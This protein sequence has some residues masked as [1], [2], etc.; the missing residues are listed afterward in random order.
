MSLYVDRFCG[1]LTTLGQKLDYF[2]TLGVN[3]LHL[4]PIMQSPEGESDG[5]GSVNMLQ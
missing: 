4:M 3:L 1:N 5:G 2:K